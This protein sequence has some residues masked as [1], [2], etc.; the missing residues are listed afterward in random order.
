MVWGEAAPEVVVRR[1]TAGRRSRRRWR[2]GGGSRRADGGEREE[3]GG[4]RE[5]AASAVKAKRTAVSAEGGEGEAGLS[6]ARDSC[7]FDAV[8]LL[9]HPF[10]ATPG[11]LPPPPRVTEPA[12]DVSFFTAAYDRGL[13]Q[14]SSIDLINPFAVL[15]PRSASPRR[16]ARNDS[17][18]R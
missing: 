10:C 5:G 8:K 15:G 18:E 17:W 16:L 12:L 6:R 13:K 4:G 3:A 11:F 9:R 2:A 7:R 1:S 14:A